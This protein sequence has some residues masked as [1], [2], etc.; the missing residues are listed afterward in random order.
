MNNYQRPYYPR[1]PV[2]SFQDLEVYQKLLAVGVVVAKRLINQTGQNDRVAALA[3]KAIDRLLRLPA[4]I[5]AAHSIRF[6][7]Q[8]QAIAK[9]EEAMLDCNLTVVYLEL[10]RDLGQGDKPSQDND[11][12]GS[13]A[14]IFFEEQIRNIL[15]TRMKIL[16]LQ[17]SWKKFM[18]LSCR[19]GS[20]SARRD[21]L[22]DDAAIHTRGSRI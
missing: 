10:Y 17:M 13:G 19:A 11:N 20:R 8:A 3:N 15:T 12:T 18:S 2:K 22:P 9:L 7:D 4:L 5:A 1:R 21:T 6:S 14:A 16:H